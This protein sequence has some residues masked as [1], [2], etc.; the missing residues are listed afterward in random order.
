M[1]G[2]QRQCRKQK[3][4]KKIRGAVQQGPGQ[5][6]SRTTSKNRKTKRRKLSKKQHRKFSELKDSDLRVQR[7]Y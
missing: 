7:A 6:N 2:K 1:Q 3:T 4:Y 5:A